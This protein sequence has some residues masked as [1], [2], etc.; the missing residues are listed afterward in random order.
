MVRIGEKIKK[1]IEFCWE[2]L[3]KKRQ[4]ERAGHR[5]ENRIKIS[6][7]KDLGKCGLDSPMDMDD[8][9]ALLNVI[10]EIVFL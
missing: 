10:M 3:T 8:C 2:N 1:Y 9:A 6:F 7:N 4:L 5:L